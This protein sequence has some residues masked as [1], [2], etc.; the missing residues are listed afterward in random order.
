MFGLEEKH[1]GDTEIRYG[2][3]ARSMQDRNHITDLNEASERPEI[4][5]RNLKSY[6]YSSF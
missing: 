1:S 3:I 5:N 6:S 4:V 2:C